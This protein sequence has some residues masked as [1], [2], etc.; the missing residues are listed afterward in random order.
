MCTW[1]FIILFFIL[2]NVC[3]K[4]PAIKITKIFNM[5][6]DIIPM[7]NVFPKIKLYEYGKKH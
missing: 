5:Q 7:R 1:A 2:L 3:L 6:Y 4:F